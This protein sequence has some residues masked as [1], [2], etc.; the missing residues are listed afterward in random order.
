MATKAKKPAAEENKAASDAVK[1]KRT[2]KAAAK[3]AEATPYE[4]VVA[5]A[6]KKAEKAKASTDFATEVTLT[7]TVEGKFYVKVSDG[8]VDVQPY[9]YKGAALTVTVDSDAF[10]E[11]IEG[12]LTA[13]SAVESGKLEMT[14]RASLMVAF[15][16]ILFA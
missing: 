14:G 6:A 15:R 7:G 2:K 16:N 12:K 13:S 9:D 11:L 10:N 3:P 8:K 4:T 1:P 5:A